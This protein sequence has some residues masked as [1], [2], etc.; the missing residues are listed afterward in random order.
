MIT[1]PTVKLVSNDVVHVLKV[2][3]F[4][5]VIRPLK[6][7]LSFRCQTNIKKEGGAGEVERLS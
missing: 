6:I 5:K 1:V 7:D 4:R 2:L 3:S